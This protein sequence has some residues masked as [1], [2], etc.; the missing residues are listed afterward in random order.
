M[1]VIQFNDDGNK[2]DPTEVRI[3]GTKVGNRGAADVVCHI[4]DTTIHRDRLTLAK[5]GD[6]KRFAT[7]IAAKLGE[8]GS[9]DRDS[10]EV[11]LLAIAE[12]FDATDHTNDGVAASRMETLELPAAC[13]VRPELIIRRDISAIAV[14]TLIQTGDQVTGNWIHYVQLNGERRLTPLSERL[15]IPGEDDAWLSPLPADPTA[16][17]VRDFNRWS[18]ESRQRWLDGEA[19]PTTKDVLRR[20]SERIERYIVLPSEGEK[21]LA[22]SL[23]A[24]VMVTYVYP[25][26]PAVPYISLSGPAN[27]GKTRTMDILSRLVFRP[28][29]TSNATAATIFRTRHA[30]GGTMLLD[31]AERMGDSHSPDVL[32]TRSVLLSGYRRGGKASRM[33]P[34]GDSYRAVSFDCYGPVVLGAIRCLPGA[35]ASRC[36][37]VR[38][39][40]ANN[41]EPQAKRSIDDSPIEESDLR[42]AL[43]CWTLESGYA[44]I[45]TPSPKH[46]LANRDAELWDPMFRIVAHADDSTALEMLI[47]HAE[48]MASISMDDATPEIDSVLFE[49]LQMLL[50]SSNTPTAGDVLR[51]ARRQHPDVIS[52]KFEP[53]GVGAILKRYDIRTV[54]TNGQRVYRT[55]VKRLVEIGNRYGFDLRVDET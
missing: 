29:M 7:D 42:D 8:A 27:S 18:S 48:S 12:Q 43:H 4:G 15:A 34:H 19:A 44:A 3:S 30:F 21:A 33:E 10:I 36:I 25:A 20:I 50:N 32:E 38:L 11:E 31:E 47:Q 16:G 14:P 1:N 13:V 22:L 46:S 53:R 35:L 45:S 17:D 39:L 54:K 9:I 40:R 23:A 41:G 2:P 37:T 49:A 26:L 24:W 55:P 52:D 51:L 6:R 5:S 28:L